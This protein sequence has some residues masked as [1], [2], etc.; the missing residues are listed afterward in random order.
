VRSA[1][2]RWA[3]SAGSRAARP[4]AK[5]RGSVR[6][7]NASVALGPLRRMTEIAPGWARDGVGVPSA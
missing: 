1:S 4:S 3:G 6:K 2:R 7:I 5:A